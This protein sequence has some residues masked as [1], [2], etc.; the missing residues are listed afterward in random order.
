MNRINKR[1]TNWHLINRI[2]QS[3][4]NDNKKNK[5]AKKLFIGRNI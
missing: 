5:N 4:H 2:R 1:D 3:K